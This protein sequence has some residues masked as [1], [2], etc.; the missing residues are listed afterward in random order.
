MTLPTPEEIKAAQEEIRRDGPMASATMELTRLVMADACLKEFVETLAANT[1]RA[2]E[3]M[4]RTKPPEI[5]DRAMLENFIR[6]A[7]VGGL[8]YGLRIK[9]KGK[10]DA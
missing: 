1:P 9:Q 6:G 4:L 5:P 3:M 8:N 2:I 10:A 7:F